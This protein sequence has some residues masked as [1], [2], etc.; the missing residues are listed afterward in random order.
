M[1]LRLSRKSAVLVADAGGCDEAVGLLE[2]CRRPPEGFSGGCEGVSVELEEVVGGRDEAPLGADG[3]ASSSSEAVHAA[4]ELRLAE[5]RL[6]HR[7]A[8]PVKRAAVVAGEDS[9]H[10]GVVAAVPAAPG[11]L[12]LGGVGG[13]QDRGAAINDAFHL[14]LMPVAGVGQQDSWAFVNARC[15]EFALRGVE[16]R[17]E[18]SEV[19]RDA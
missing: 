11:T 7:L 2:T 13:N 18:L 14:L 16:H 12:A 17:F 8:L 6:D 5:H 3:G 10:E 1:C 15:C 9:A 4:V 19:R